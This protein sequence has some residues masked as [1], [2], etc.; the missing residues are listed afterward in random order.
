MLLDVFCQTYLILVL[1]LHKLFLGSLVISQI[2]QFFKLRQICY[3]FPARMPCTPVC[4]QRIAMSQ[5]STLGNSVCLIIEFFREKL[6]KVLK[7]LIFK[8]LCMKSCNTIYRVASND[9]H[10]CHLYLTI[11]QDCHVSDFVAIARVSLLNLHYKSSVDFIYNLVHTRKQS[12]ENVYRP[13]FKCLC[14][15]C[16]VCVCNTAGSNVPCLIP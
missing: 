15:D 10:V 3:P 11:I 1:N 9:C 7:L 14:H 2:C 16:M 8:Y 5:K 13:L 6:I 12:L 4:Q